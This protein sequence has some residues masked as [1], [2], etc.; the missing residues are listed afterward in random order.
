[1]NKEIF[2]IF[3]EIFICLVVILVAIFVF[4]NLED[5]YNKEK[6]I[7]ESLNNNLAIKLTDY[8]EKWFPMTDEYAINNLVSNKI[9]ISNCGKRSSDYS[10]Y[11]RIDRDSTV[12]DS[13]LKILFNNKI[14]D[15]DSLY[16]Y[17]DSNY[18]YYILYNSNIDDYELLEYNIYLK[19]N[20]MMN[21]NSL[22]YAFVLV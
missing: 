10:L 3:I 22:S 21:G 2:K 9:E 4:P 13:E 5:K 1:M 12:K 18:N 16:N 6:S 11:L 8:G 15:L 7:V 17:A 19:D 14:Y 20:A